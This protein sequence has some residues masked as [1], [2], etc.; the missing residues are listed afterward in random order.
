MAIT[1]FACSP[2]YIS[3]S[4]SDETD[5]NTSVLQT[6]VSCSRMIG[7]A[8]PRRESDDH[9]PPPVR[10]MDQGRNGLNLAESEREVFDGMK[11]V[12]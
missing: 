10:Q 4:S 3:T 11:R 5:K 6:F 2:R 12:T 1:S 8:R 9:A 7:E